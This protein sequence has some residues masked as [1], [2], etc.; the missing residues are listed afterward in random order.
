MS[1]LAPSISLPD[2]SLKPSGPESTKTR[3]SAK[4]LMKNNPALARLLVA[5]AK[6]VKAKQEGSQPISSTPNKRSPPSQGKYGV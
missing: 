3:F 6:K 1:K 2:A 5:A 4:D